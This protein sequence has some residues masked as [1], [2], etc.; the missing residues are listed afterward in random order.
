MT[1]ETRADA[2]EVKVE[3]KQWGSVW[4]STSAA[5][6]CLPTGLRSGGQLRQA[7]RNFTYGRSDGHPHLVCEKVIYQKLLTASSPPLCELRTPG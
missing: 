3:S 7:R 1:Q 6:E 4:R 5:F 2:V